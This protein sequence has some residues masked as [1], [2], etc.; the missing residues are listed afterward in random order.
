MAEEV[1][2]KHPLLEREFIMC[3]LA[4]VG[5]IVLYLKGEKEFAMTL[6]SVGVG[7]LAL[8]RGLAKGGVAKMMA[9]CVILSRVV[10]CRGMIPVS[11]IE[12]PVDTIVSRHNDLIDGKIDLDKISS[13]KKESWK[14]TGAL[15]IRQLEA[16]K[17]KD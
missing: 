12:K 13:A 6:I 15:L 2:K 10:G 9:I 5:G 3:V 4:F 17:K 16:A 1:K 14:R 7:G 8:S 11:D